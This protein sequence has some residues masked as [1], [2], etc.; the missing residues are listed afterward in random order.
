MNKKQIIQ[1]ACGKNGPMSGIK[2]TSSGITGPINNLRPETGATGNIEAFKTNERKS[3]K[4]LSFQDPGAYMNSGVRGLVDKIKKKKTEQV[5]QD[6]P[7]SLNLKIKKVPATN[8]PVAGT[9]FSDLQGVAKPVSQLNPIQQQEW[10]RKSIPLA[11][12]QVKKINK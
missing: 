9:K 7:S 4:G 1:K 6:L 5:T 12:K 10:F 8:I 2:N 11:N 3:Q